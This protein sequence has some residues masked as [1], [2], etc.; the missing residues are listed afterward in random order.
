MGQRPHGRPVGPGQAIDC[1]TVEVEAG[2]VGDYRPGPAVGRFTIESCSATE[3][4]ITFRD[5]AAGEGFQ[6]KYQADI[7]DL[8]WTVHQQCRVRRSMD[9]S[10]P[11]STTSIRT[12]C[13]RR[14]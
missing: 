3:L 6:V 10:G 2:P 12:D 14:R 4:V 8:T 5:A 1:A 7:T 11:A 9:R 13:R